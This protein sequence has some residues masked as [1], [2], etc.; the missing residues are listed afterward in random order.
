MKATELREKSAEQLNEQLLTLL[1]DQFNLRM[2]KATGQ[3]GQSHL[4]K[5]AKR[6]IARVKT[7]LNQKGG[8]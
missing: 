5:Q 3:L 7:V 2:Q 6:D 8:N 4:L 1:R